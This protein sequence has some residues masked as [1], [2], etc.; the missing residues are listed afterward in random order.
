M[1]GLAAVLWLLQLILTDSS[2]T[3]P[4]ARLKWPR[5]E[6]GAIFPDLNSLYLP[7]LHQLE[8]EHVCDLYDTLVQSHPCCSVSLRHD[9][10]IDSLK[11]LCEINA[12]RGGAMVIG[13]STITSV[14]QVIQCKNSGSKFISTMTTTKTIYQKAVELDMNI[15]CGVSTYSEA[16][17]C[18]EWGAK[19][20]KF[21]PASSV[22]PSKLK[23][24]LK[25]INRNNNEYSFVV[26]GG[27]Q[28]TDV[29]PYLNA[30]ATGFALGID[31]KKLATEE[32]ANKLAAFPIM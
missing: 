8:P 1:A 3:L 22:P 29:V 30:G 15:M 26:A 28:T 32:I 11:L 16:I 19:S 24:I 21:Y 10:A 7:V 27:I 17:A 6:S 2:L 14:E 25:L 5:C 4:S 23:E 13:A 12:V 9:S 31:C 18:L 20:L